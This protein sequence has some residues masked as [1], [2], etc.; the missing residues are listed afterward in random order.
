MGY[1]FRP[2]EREQ[3]YLLPPSLLDWLPPDDLVWFV[4]DVV[5]ELDLGPFLARYRADGWGA[6]A[7]APRLMVA[8]LLY[9]YATGER[10]SRRIETLCRRDIA[11]RV[12]C[13][14]QVPDHA[15]I[16]RF[17]AEHA[18]ALEQLFGQVLRLCARA[19][20]V[21]LGLIALDGT[22]IA[23][24]AS[25]DASRTAESLEA[26]IR[27]ILDEAAVADAAEDAAPGPERP[28]DEL[29]P[30]LAQRGSR[31]ARLREARRQI[32]AD[33]A[34]RQARYRERV[35]ERE[36]ADPATRSRIRPPTR[37]QPR[38]RRGNATDPDSRAMRSHGVPVQAYN[39]QLVATADGIA[40]AADVSQEPSDA[41]RLA[42]MLAA[43]RRNL[44]AAGVGKRPGVLLADGGY[45][46]EVTVAHLPLD[47]P[48]LLIPPSVGRPGQRP[49]RQWDLPER[50]T[51]LRRF[52]SDV[53]RRLYRRRAAII[54]P[55]FGHLKENRGVRRFQCRGL[56]A[57]R[58][59][60]QLL[61]TTH[62]LLKLWR[63]APHPHAYVTA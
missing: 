46:S 10:S 43:T 23:A 37:P 11:Y 28:G 44:R 16:A 14:N 9:A 13:A 26:E 35:A 54:E 56:A 53:A 60:W 1:N 22:K 51:M 38:L 4:L 25:L 2:V 55:L 7:F 18:A 48:T 27:A 29:P 59:E 45:W 52:E 36:A 24:N 47:R 21:R 42:P 63:R 3:Q 40:I 32:D 57:C 20:L 34:Q 58:S 8:L 49:G 33:E 19:G 12:I 30:E 50:D 31:L 17:R 6:P 62:N 41:I 15:T 61:W 39:G 5:D